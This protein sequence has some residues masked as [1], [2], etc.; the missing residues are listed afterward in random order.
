MGQGSFD[1]SLFLL[2]SL[3]VGGIIQVRDAGPLNA[4]REV[5][6]R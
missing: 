4:K 5:L 3:R 6:T 2:R 1:Q